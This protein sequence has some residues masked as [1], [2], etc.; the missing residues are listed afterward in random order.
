MKTLGSAA[1]EASILYRCELGV[2]SRRILV[3]CPY[4]AADLFPQSTC[5]PGLY[6]RLARGRGGVG[7]EK[8]LGTGQMQPGAAREDPPNGRRARPERPQ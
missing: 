4:R 2:R 5:P 3:E 8:R 7:R 6:P 1:L